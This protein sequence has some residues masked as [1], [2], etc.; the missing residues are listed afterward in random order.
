M[1]SVV[2]TSNFS[3]WLFSDPAGICGHKDSENEFATYEK[4]ENEFDIEQVN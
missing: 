3:I 4:K 2:C 1:G